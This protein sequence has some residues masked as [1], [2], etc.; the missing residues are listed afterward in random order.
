M[1]NLGDEQMVAEV[2][3]WIHDKLLT[4]EHFVSLSDD[5]AEAI[6]IQ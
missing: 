6:Q 5:E 2:D 3:N 1:Q 4:L